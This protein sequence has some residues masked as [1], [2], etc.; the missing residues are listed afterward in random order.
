MH[1]WLQI[2]SGQGPAECCWVVHHVVQRIIKE[3][4]RFGL[5]AVTL[6]AVP[7]P[8][9]QTFK[10]VLLAIEGENADSF[11]ERW[12]GT[13]LWIGTSPYRPH[14]KRKNWYIGV[15]SL[16][17]PSTSSFSEKDVKIETM[18]ASGPG[19]QHVNKTAS[20]VRVTH[21]KTN[22]SA[23]AREERSQYQ[24][25]R[26]ALARLAQAL[27]E[28]EKRKGQEKQQQL[29]DLHQSLERGN[30]VRV[31]EGNEFAEKS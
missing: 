4:A 16:L 17:P 29:W 18:R 22:I 12:E 28:E 11:C 15:N 3:S 5:K 20:A 2:T 8:E 7:G 1:T 30:P 31:F 21:L 26:L 23:I 6:D 9:H 19:G 25:R 24:N 10:S 14:H 27:E 13:I